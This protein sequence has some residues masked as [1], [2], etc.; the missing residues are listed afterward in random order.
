MEQCFESVSEGAIYATQFAWLYKHQRIGKFPFDPQYRVGVAWDLGMSKTDAMALWFYQT[1][2]RRV[3]LVD[4]FEEKGVGQGWDYYKKL[5]DAYASD[6]GYVYK[7]HLAPHDIM[8]NEYAGMTRIE[9]AA[10]M[11]IVFSVP[12]KVTPSVQADIDRVKTFM[13]G[14]WFNEDTC[15]LG[16]AALKGYKR[17]YNIATRTYSDNPTHDWSSHGSDAFRTLAMNLKF[18]DLY[19]AVDERPEADYAML[20]T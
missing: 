16:L 13:L 5:L 17:K 3:Y 1:V 19:R 4:Y 8:R 14:C 9:S 15:G 2:G 10:R 20:Y 18:D 11:G 7:E 6:K 12:Q